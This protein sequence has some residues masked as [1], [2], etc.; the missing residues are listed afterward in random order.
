VEVQR[1]KVTVKGKNVGSSMPRDTARIK[2]SFGL[3]I[4][5]ITQKH[6]VT[7]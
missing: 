4:T 1:S 2:L 3:Y 7:Q 6:M 5:M